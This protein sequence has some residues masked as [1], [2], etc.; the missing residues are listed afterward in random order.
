MRNRICECLSC[1]RQADPTK[2]DSRCVCGNRAWQLCESEF[3]GPSILAN[4]ARVARYF[5]TDAGRPFTAGPRA[6]VVLCEWRGEYVTWIAVRR[7]HGWVAYHGDYYA[8]RDEAEEGYRSRISEA[9]R[10]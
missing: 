2:T 7:S 3:A 10:R 8:T 1:G 4:G 5:E 9:V 6:G